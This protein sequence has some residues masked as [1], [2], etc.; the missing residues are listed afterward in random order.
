MGVLAAAIGVSE[1]IKQRR[2]REHGNTQSTEP[3][4]PQPAPTSPTL[5]P[6]RRIAD[7][8]PQP[9]VEALQLTGRTLRTRRIPPSALHS[10]PAAAPQAA[11]A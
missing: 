11:R 3:R 6:D 9:A 4:P 7:T 2:Q 5:P 8:P 10:R 1:W